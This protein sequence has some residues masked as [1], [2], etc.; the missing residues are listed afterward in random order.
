[1]ATKA[2]MDDFM[3]EAVKFS[4]APWRVSPTFR[5][6]ALEVTKPSVFKLFSLW[7]ANGYTVN[8]LKP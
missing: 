3:R 7:W 6:A 8:G 5:K 1:M 2:E 4:N